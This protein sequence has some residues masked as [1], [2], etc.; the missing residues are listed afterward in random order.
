MRYACAYAMRFMLY[1]YVFCY[2]LRSTFAMGRTSAMLNVCYVN[3]VCAM[4]YLYAYWLCFTRYAMRYAMSLLT[5]RAILCLCLCMLNHSHAL[6][7]GITDC[8]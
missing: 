4:L 1:L 7:V 5:M 6:P 2:A 8:G 3:Y